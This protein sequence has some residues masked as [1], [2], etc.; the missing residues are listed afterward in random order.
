LLGTRRKAFAKLDSDGNGA[1]RFE[2]WAPRTISKFEG[3]DGVRT[4]TEYA[5]TAP[6]P[7]KHKICSCTAA[8]SSASIDY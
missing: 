6:P 5:T 3:A 8:P 2:E 1:L 4:A 7:P